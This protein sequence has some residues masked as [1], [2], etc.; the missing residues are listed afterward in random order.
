MSD[1]IQIIWSLI[2]FFYS[3]FIIYSI[4]LL[5][6]HYYYCDY[7]CDYDYDCD[8]SEYDCNCEYFNFVNFK[9]Y[10]ENYQ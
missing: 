4:N 5:N 7:D 8:D 10:S 3:S 2:N 9:I 1:D 6:Y